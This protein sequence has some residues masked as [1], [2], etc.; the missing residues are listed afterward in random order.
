[1]R[2]RREPAVLI[3][4]PCLMYNHMPAPPKDSPAKRKPERAG[5]GDT[6]KA[7]L[8]LFKQGME[9]REW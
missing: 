6:R 8:E 7:G 5:R 2:R 4:P 9:I 1:M 3:R